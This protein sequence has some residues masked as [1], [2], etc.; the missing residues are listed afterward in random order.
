M[1]TFISVTSEG[2]WGGLAGEGKAAGGAGEWAGEATV[3]WR[4]TLHLAILFQ[5]KQNDLIT[6]HKEATQEQMVEL[7]VNLKQ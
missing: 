4:S 5:K 3:S 1:N 2:E 7:Q 6:A